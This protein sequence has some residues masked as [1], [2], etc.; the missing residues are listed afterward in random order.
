MVGS[1]FEYGCGSGQDMFLLSVTSR[2]SL[3]PIHTLIQYEM[4]LF[5]GAKSSRA[6]I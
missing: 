2:A 6:L 3:E 4:Y 1:G 5:P